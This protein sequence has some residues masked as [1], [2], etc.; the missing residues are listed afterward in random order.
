MKSIIFSS[1]VCSKCN[2]KPFESGE[3]H[4]LRTP[5]RDICCTCGNVLQTFPAVTDVTV[6]KGTISIPAAVSTVLERLLTRR[7]YILDR[8]RQPFRADRSIFDVERMAKTLAHRAGDQVYIK[9]RGPGNCSA[10]L[11]WNYSSK[12]LLPRHPWQELEYNPEGGRSSFREMSHLKPH[13]A[14]VE[15]PLPSRISRSCDALDGFDL[16]GSILDRNDR[17]RRSLRFEQ[18]VDMESPIL[19]TTEDL[20]L[21]IKVELSWLHIGSSFPNEDGPRVFNVSAFYQGYPQSLGEAVDLA[22]YKATYGRDQETIEIHHSG[23]RLAVMGKVQ[24]PLVLFREPRQYYMSAGPV[25]KNESA[26]QPGA[27]A[28]E[29][30]GPFDT[31]D[32]AWLIPEGLQYHL[33]VSMPSDKRFTDDR[34]PPEVHVLIKHGEE[35]ILEHLFG[36]PEHKGGYS[37]YGYRIGYTVVSDKLKALA[38]GEIVRTII[39]DN[40]AS[41]ERVYKVVSLKEYEA[42]WDSW[43][44]PI[45][46]RYKRQMIAE[47]TAGVRSYFRT[48]AREAAAAEL[49]GGQKVAAFIDGRWVEGVY[50][51]RDANGEQIVAVVTAAGSASYVVSLVLPLEEALTEGLHVAPPFSGQHST[52][53]EAQ[54]LKA[55]V[56]GPLV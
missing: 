24:N 17:C 39:T 7:L 10:E 19:D 54:L 43:R 50:K 4:V 37:Q 28:P 21:I 49:K 51:Q 12:V 8:G 33:S 22:I 27:S 53:S 29:Y 6:P 55:A 25:A 34:V 46:E 47:V 52:G 40:G 56:S 18:R 32:G 44:N 26:L 3:R 23:E 41:V 30:Q 16:L 11:R 13:L 36:G 38:A 31:K 15:F 20:V 45:I 14:N 5:T 1:H 2:E 48:G 42:A 35:T 9:L